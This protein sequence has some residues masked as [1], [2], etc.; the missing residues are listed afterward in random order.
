M[1]PEVSG[2]GA[3]A[4]LDPASDKA[5][6]FVALEDWLND[7]VPLAGPVALECLQDW[8]VENRPMKRRWQIAGAAIDPRQ[9]TQPSFLVVPRADRIVPPNSAL[10]L[11]HEL[12]QT[13][14]L[15]PPL[16]HIGMVTSARARAAVWEP[17][18]RWLAADL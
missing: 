16:G 17:L 4:A 11:A 6:E 13:Q 1:P 9:I 3:F 12:A 5:R 2:D 18:A 10:G 15:R 14:I 7:G 8:Y